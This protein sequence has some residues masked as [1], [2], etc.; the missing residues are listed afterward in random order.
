MKPG[1]LPDIGALLKRTWEVFKRRAGVLI[2]LYLLSIVMFLVPLAVSI[3]I[4]VMV[5]TALS[6]SVVWIVAI[7]SSLGAGAGMVLGYWAFAAMIFAIVDEQL[8][9]SAAFRQGWSM[10]WP[11]IWLYM[12]Q[13]FIVVGGLMFFVVPGVIFATWFF[14]AAYILV[15]DGQHGFDALFKS[16]EYVGDRCSEVFVRLL[17]IVLISFALNMVPLVGWLSSFVFPP[18]MMLY[19]FLLYRDLKALRPEPVAFESTTARKAKFVGAGALGHF[20]LVVPIVAG[21]LI[22]GAVAKKV[23]T[24]GPA[25][26]GVSLKRTGLEGKWQ[27]KEGFFFFLDIKDGV[28]DANITGVDFI[29]ARI[30]VTKVQPKTSTIDGRLTKVLLMDLGIPIK[31]IYRIKDNELTLCFARKRPR[32]FNAG[33]CAE[34]TRVSGGAEQISM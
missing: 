17:V 20:C 8:D 16:K 23:S 34:F 27:G 3:G 24:P 19:M 29:N 14:A 12:L 22:M 15:E 31:G 21:I 11:F 25:P 9:I 5:A 13:M 2:V 1:G 30:V 18:F 7:F 26:P 10:L 33:N 32:G 4:G 6:T 28:I